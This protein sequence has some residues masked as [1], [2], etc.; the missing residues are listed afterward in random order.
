MTVSKRVWP[1]LRGLVLGGAAALVFS[2]SAIAPGSGVA[3]PP[4]TLPEFKHT[5]ADAWIN[6][7]PLTKAGLRGK[8][9]LIEVYTSG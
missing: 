5:N 3:G 4:A 6:S 1:G 7:P 8:V 9:V 2:L